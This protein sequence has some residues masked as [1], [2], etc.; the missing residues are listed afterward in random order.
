ML[1][2][3]TG[4]NGG[5][6]GQSKGR[7]LHTLRT[8]R[9]MQSMMTNARPIWREAAKAKGDATIDLS[10]SRPAGTA[11]SLRK[12]DVVVADTKAETTRGEDARLA[13]ATERTSD[14]G[15]SHH[16]GMGPS[17]S[18]EIGAGTSPEER[19]SDPLSRA[20]SR[21]RG[22]G[23]ST[24]R[25][26]PNRGDHHHHTQYGVCTATK[27]EET[28]GGQNGE[29]S[30]TNSHTLAH[31]PHHD[32]DTSAD[33]RGASMTLWRRG[34][35]QG[36]TA[37]LTPCSERGKTSLTTTWTHSSTTTTPG[38]ATTSSNPGGRE[39]NGARTSGTT[40]KIG[41]CRCT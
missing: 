2:A 3:S 35:T 40:R 5:P 27:V 13:H 26:S 33:T 19:T 21:G 20:T 14:N 18:R 9:R 31:H 32:V 10:R 15:R 39:A 29:C 30:S 6:K 16:G 17:Q 28:P 22:R 25:G 23:V 37:T 38:R 1:L 34:P 24:S 41:N 11:S 4:T 7:P 12:E 8:R 36:T